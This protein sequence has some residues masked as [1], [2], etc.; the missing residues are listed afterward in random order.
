MILNVGQLMKHNFQK[1]EVS[2]TYGILQISSMKNNY[3][4]PQT[5]ISAK[6]LYI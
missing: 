5:N 4:S 1:Q 2:G 6:I 3:W